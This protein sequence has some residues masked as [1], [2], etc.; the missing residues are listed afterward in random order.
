MRRTDGHPETLLELPLIQEISGSEYIAIQS[1]WIANVDR[2]SRYLWVVQLRRRCVSGCASE[3]K[4]AL[5]AVANICAVQPLNG[6]LLDALPMSCRCVSRKRSL[7]ISGRLYVSARVRTCLARG[8]SN[9]AEANRMV[10]FRS[11]SL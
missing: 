3:Y 5:N 6:K 2:A 4:C 7:S 8:L 9:G 10:R 11:N 1:A